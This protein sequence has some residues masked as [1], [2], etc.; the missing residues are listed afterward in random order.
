M[1]K[2]SSRLGLMPRGFTLM[3]L[4]VTLALLGLLALLAAPL[5]ELSV[6]RSREVALRQALYDIRNALDRYKIAFDQGFI[7]RRPGDSGYPADLRVLVNGIENQRSPTHE[8]LYFLRRIPR[9]P[10]APTDM[11]AE[12]T[13]GL[14]AY[15]SPPDSPFPGNDVFDVYSQTKGKGL[16]GVLYEEW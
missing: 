9:D 6:Q 5:V 2:R 14:R 11:L 7:Q 15:N 10:F 12:N 16:N 3:E 4:V 8:R 1:V 13:W